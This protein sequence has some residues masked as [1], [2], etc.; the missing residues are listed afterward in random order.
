MEIKNGIDVVLENYMIV[1]MDDPFYIEETW[2]LIINND[3]SFKLVTIQMTE[4]GHRS[5]S[6]GSDSQYRLDLSLSDTTTI[7]K[8]LNTG[9]FD[10]ILMQ[11]KQNQ[12]AQNFGYINW[13]TKPDRKIIL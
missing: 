4:P 8:G 10:E 12:R 2:G 11:Y 3:I 7:L 1:R 9:F 5:P 13:T 6:S